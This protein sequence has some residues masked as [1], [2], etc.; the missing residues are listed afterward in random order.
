MPEPGSPAAEGQTTDSPTFVDRRR[1]GRVE[2]SSPQLIEMMRGQTRLDPAASLNTCIP[3]ENLGIA[4]DDSDNLSAARGILTG[5]V[6]A[7]PL[8]A[9]IG[10]GAWFL[11]RG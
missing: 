11:L 6:L 8:W 7:L 5:V 3:F 1:P 9:L 2:Y 10:A 4:S